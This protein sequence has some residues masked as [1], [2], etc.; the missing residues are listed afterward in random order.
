MVTRVP[1]T[2]LGELK[3]ALGGSLVA[4]CQS[5]AGGECVIAGNHLACP[6]SLQKVPVV[7]SSGCM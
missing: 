3:E 5:V 1:E 4:D 7:E 2:C 6:W